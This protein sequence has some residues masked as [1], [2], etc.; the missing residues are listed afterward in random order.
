MLVTN[1]R[2]AAA[3]LLPTS[4]HNSINDQAH[5]TN[6]GVLQCLCRLELAAAWQP[7]RE[8]LHCACMPTEA[9][10]F[11]QPPSALPQAQWR[12]CKDT[13]LLP[14]ALCSSAAPARRSTTHARVQAIMVG[15][16]K[17]MQATCITSAASKALHC[18]L[19]QLQATTL[20][21]P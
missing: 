2:R 20:A 13:A 16:Y 6:I 5:Q 17:H 18:L 8:Q 19:H 1:R 4:S 14:A 10:T 9:C 3:A 7:T 11:T 15:Y 21:D 12:S